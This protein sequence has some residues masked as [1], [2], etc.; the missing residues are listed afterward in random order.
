MTKLPKAFVLALM[1]AASLFLPAPDL[2][3]CSRYLVTNDYYCG[4]AGPCQPIV[5][6]Y[7]GEDANW[8]Y[9]DC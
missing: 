6:T 2:K 8:C 1:L 5:C 9:Y 7:S 4:Y 3:A